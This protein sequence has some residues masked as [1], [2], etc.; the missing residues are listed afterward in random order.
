MICTLDHQDKA[1]GEDGRNA[2][3]SRLVDER[4]LCEL[5]STSDN[6]QVNI[7]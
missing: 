2:N 5:S 6:I 4:L 7:W 1:V 3:R